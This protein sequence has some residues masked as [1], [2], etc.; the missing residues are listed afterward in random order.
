M[1]N[2]ESF[3]DE[4]TEELRRDQ[5]YAMLRRYGWIAVLAVLLLVGGAAWNEWNKAQTEAQAQAVGDALLSALE[6]NDPAGRVEGLAAIDPQGPAVAVT[7]LFTA[8]E[9]Q[10]SG[11]TAA[12]IATLDALAVDADIPDEYRGLAALKSLML[13][14]D[15]MDPAERRIA[16]E[17]LAVPGNPYR[18]LALEQL[19]LADVSAGDIEAALFGLAAIVE[20]AEATQSLRERA[21]GLIVALGGTIDANAGN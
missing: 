14:A 4:V 20:D 15:T 11:D 12:A 5:L 19:A 9:Q 1:S 18:M 6:V 2:N 21:Q 13:S 16:L 3:I 7:A 17:A 8:A 10:N